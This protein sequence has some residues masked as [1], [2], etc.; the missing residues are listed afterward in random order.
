MKRILSLNLLFCFIFVLLV[1]SNLLTTAISEYYTE[2]FEGSVTLSENW[3]E[4]SAYGTT[5]WNERV[6]TDPS[7]SNNKVY[8]I[9]WGNHS[10]QLLKWNKP[11]SSYDFSVDV[12]VEE[13]TLL[14]ME[15]VPI[16]LQYT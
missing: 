14:L 10:P 15:L 16:L 2:D 12:K 6:V 5:T 11:L 9:E 7:D 13:A 3:L 1:P 8:R 4:K